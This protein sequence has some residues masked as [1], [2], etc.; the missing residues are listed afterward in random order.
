MLTPKDL[1]NHEFQVSG[2][3]GYLAADVDDY[4]EE[5]YSSYDQMFRENAEIVRKLQVLA[6][7][8]KKY[9]DDEEN[10]RSALVE[11]QRIKSSII[12]EAQQKA[13][14]QLTE[15]EEKIRA[16]KESAEERADE[17]LEKARTEAD[18]IRRDARAEAEELMDRTNKK[19]TDLLDTANSIYEEKVTTAKAEVEKQ[20]AY[21][22]KIKAE[23]AKVRKQLS[24]TYQMQME[25]LSFAP[26]FTTEVEQPVEEI[27][28]EE[29]PV[30]ETFVTSEEVLGERAYRETQAR[31]EERKHSAQVPVSDEDEPEDPSVSTADDDGFDE[32]DKYLAGHAEEED[33]VGN[34][35][36]K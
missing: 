35:Y 30:E 28:E 24:D 21:F 5:V 20:A 15:T 12:V 1:R 11:A 10:I 32:I 31:L 25:L 19:A 22:E 2:R 14:D 34:K 6:D 17:I 9:K 26:D 23:S 8:L 16:A 36:F 13:Q 27:K 33:R 3:N 4:L 29:A 7:R 18:E